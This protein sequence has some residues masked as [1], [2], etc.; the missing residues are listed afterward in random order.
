MANPQ[1]ALERRLQFQRSN[2]QSFTGKPHLQ[3]FH[4]QSESR[5]LCYLEDTTQDQQWQEEIFHAQ[6]WMPS[7]TLWVAL[8]RILRICCLLS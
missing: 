6:K 4:Q 5:L 2:G 3:A 1:E 8:P 7:D